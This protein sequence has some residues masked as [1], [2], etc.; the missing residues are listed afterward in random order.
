[1]PSSLKDLAKSCATILYS[2]KTLININKNRKVGY[3]RTP[4][5]YYINY[6]T[7]DWEKYK[8][9]Q[10]NI[11]ELKIKYYDYLIE[12]NSHYRLVIPKEEYNCNT[13]QLQKYYDDFEIVL[14]SWKTNGITSIHGHAKNGCIYGVLD[15]ILLERMYF[16]NDNKMDNKYGC[17]NNILESG[18]VKYI[19]NNM[20]KHRIFNVNDKGICECEY[21]QG[22]PIY[23]CPKPITN[24]YSLHIYSPPGYFENNYTNPKFVDNNTDEFIK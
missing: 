5:E 4:F 18:D 1:M 6:N 2:A 20:G 19:D 24:S 17:V 16:N 10:Y 9:N 8:C 3:F 21:I 14:M 23:N 13:E 15:G 22:E 11:N 7:G 12:S